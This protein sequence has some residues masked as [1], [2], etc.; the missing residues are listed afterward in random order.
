MKLNFIHIFY[1]IFLLLVVPSLNAQNKEAVISGFVSNENSGEALIGANILLYKD[2]ISVKQPPFSAAAANRYGFYALPNLQNGIYII[3]VRHI[4]YKTL[5]KEVDISP[6]KSSIQL[7]IKL[8]PEDIKLQ[9]V[10]VTGEKQKESEIS[11]IDVSPDLLSKLPSLS[12]EVD[13]FKLLQLLPGIQTASEISNG[14]YVRGGS[15]DQTLTL[16]DGVIVYNPSH[17]GNIASTFNSYA[18]NDVKLIKGAFP[19]EYGGRLSS[20]LDIKLRSGTKERN[21]AHL[22][23]GLINAFGTLEVLWEII[24]HI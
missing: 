10:I 3:I 20:V 17:M 2:S 13:L 8:V 21:K 12:G 11:T 22:G 16:V 24:Q 14:L 18:I 19:A 7:N 5:I 15:P 1:I 6:A 4:G 9:E 23:L